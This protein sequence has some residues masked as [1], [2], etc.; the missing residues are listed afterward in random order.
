M[1]TL[2]M[3]ALVLVSTTAW[4]QTFTEGVHYTT[5]EN[6]I[7]TDA[8]SVEVTEAFSYLCN[9][10]KTFEPY[11]QAW[12]ARLP[13]GVSFT[14]IPVE[15]GRAAWG[16]YARGYVA[17]SVLGIEEESHVPMMDAIWVKRRQMRNLEELADFY[18]QY[19]VEKEQFLA[20]AQSFAVDMRIRKEQQIVRE[21]GVNGT[22]TLLVAGK[23][24]I[25]AGGANSSF[26][27]ML[28]VV[29]HLVAKE[30]AERMAANTAEPAATTETA[31]AE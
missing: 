20:T 14:R 25:N 29:D 1:K 17:A 10:C 8:D 16:L 31:A 2:L 5:L 15:F 12:L 4:A 27:A 28:A 9:H 19:G 6:P 26:D 11:M 3:T 22:P 30:L 13:E 21:A 23:Y 24:R 18:A 7:P